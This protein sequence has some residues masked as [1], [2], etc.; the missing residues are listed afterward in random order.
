M[1]KTR[2]ACSF[3]T[4]LLAL[5]LGS[6]AWAASI[7]GT[8]T[9]STGKSG[10]IYLTVYQ[11]GGSINHGTSIDAAGAFTISGVPAGTPY[12]VRAFVDTQ[13]TGIQHAND[14]RGNSVTVT[15]PATGN[16]SV[17]SFAVATPAPVAAQAPPA[18]VYSGAGVNFVK[19]QG[20]MDPNGLPV[21]D[22]YIVSWSTSA[23]GAP[24][25]GTREVRSGQDDY[26]VQTGTSSL[27]Y[28]ITAVAGASNASTGWIQ[29]T[30]SAGSGSVTGKVLF[31]GSSATGPLYVALI[32][33]FVNPPVV[34]VAAVASPASG[35]GY[36]IGNVPAGSYNIIPFL[37]QNGNGSLDPGDNALANSNDYHPSVTVAASQVAAPELTLDTANA[38]RRLFVGHGKSETWEW[39]NLVFYAQSMKKQLVK[40]RV[41]SGPQITEP[42]D[43]SLTG[44]HFRTRIG[45][46]R[47]AVGDS[48][49][50]A[51]SYSDGSSET[52]AVAVTGILDGFATPTAPVGYQ[53][54][55]PTPTFSWS[56][57]APAPADFVYSI[58]MSAADG[59]DVWDAW[60]L[61]SSRT[62]V[63]Y[64][65]Q[66]EV[67][68]PA[69]TDGTSYNW[70]VNVTDR[71]GNMT[72][73]Q[74]SFTTTSSPALTGFAPAGGLAGTRVTLAGINFSTDTAS[75]AVLFNNAPATVVSASGNSLTVTV[76]GGATTG[77]IK[78][79]T[80]G[81]T[82]VSQKPFIVAAAIN[83]KGALLTAANLPIAG[84]LVA[85]ADDPSIFASTAA[86]GGF[87]LQPL[88]PGQN[89]TL[90]LTKSGYVPTYSS[91]FTLQGSLDLTPYPNHLYTKAN[92]TG[93]GVAAG[94]GVIIGQLQNTGATPSLPVANAQVS[95]TGSL[96]AGSSYPASYYNGSTFGGSSTWANGVFYLLNLLDFDYVNV[97]AA[98]P[99]WIFGV[100][101]FS[102]RA[103][104]V[105]E[106][107]I[108][109]S[110]VPPAITSFAPA[111]GKTGSSVVISGVN[112]SA[113]AA[114]NTVIFNGVNATVT[115]ATA[116]KVTATVPAAATSG[117]IS[118]ITAGAK[119]TSFTN[120]I[121]SQTLTASVTGSGTVTSVPV[122]ISCRTA[123]CTALFDQGSTVEMVATADAGGTLST[124]SGACTGNGPCVLTMNADKSVSAA[125]AG[126]L[127]YIKKGASYYAL[128]QSAFDA[129]ATGE[130]I[131]AQARVFT[132]TA[133]HFNRPLAQVHLKGGYDDTF[134]TN[135]GFTTLDGRLNL[136]AGTLRVEKVRVR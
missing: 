85:V 54:F 28:R 123:G 104:S 130:T 72:A 31:P 90:K 77:T 76:P 127:N 50:L 10:R 125:F 24:V 106:G 73:R 119:S 91:S 2:E 112:F 14:P 126:G 98:K 120:F 117:P 18:T 89:V 48:Y 42:V 27:Y 59:T 81:K 40:V 135:G 82:L 37:D 47:P 136:Q 56:A 58:W 55:D 11:N 61:P 57:P 41:A 93:W 105:T 33:E 88:F 79:T 16:V 70:I 67:S 35:A 71:N 94:R 51:L 83:I 86:N 108:I 80:G 95:A 132:N 36:S 116:T 87:T 124:W 134:S 15:L 74:T 44:N 111:S 12:L 66:G 52:A 46:S 20:G 3:V 49:Q 23:T 63:L 113:V 96:N 29:V 19:W 39:Y 100:T 115:A 101:G 78:L 45:V 5:L 129:A 69:L 68:K 65:S 1:V 64:G 110:T 121:V 131:Q 13:G 114:E 118:V 17:G 26:F 109:G 53:P 25:A 21:A 60:R 4:L 103:D 62:S 6:S 102:V 43:V 75:H 128:L 34:R 97:T 92:L 8:V 84:A 30:S 133:C 32:N 7:S 122:G 107:V 22:K 9:N 99:A 38:S